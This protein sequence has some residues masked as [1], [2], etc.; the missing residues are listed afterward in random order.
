MQ[1][2]HCLC[3]NCGT[4]WEFDEPQNVGLVND[5]MVCARSFRVGQWCGQHFANVFASWFTSPACPQCS[6]KNSVR[7]RKVACGP[8]QYLR[9]CQD[10][11]AVWIARS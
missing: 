2:G 1:V 6:G 5:C 9:Q 8:N 3:P 10:C 4:L 7:C 11:W